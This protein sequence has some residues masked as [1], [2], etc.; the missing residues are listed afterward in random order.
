MKAK[1]KRHEAEFKARV[2]LEA[3]KGIKTV[4]EIAK[5]YPT[6]LL[7]LCSDTAHAAYLPGPD[8]DLSGQTAKP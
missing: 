4:Q 1:C 8:D 2:V 7:R 5:E 3:L 6:G